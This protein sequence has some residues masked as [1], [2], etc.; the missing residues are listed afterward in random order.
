MRKIGFYLL[1]LLAMVMV[2]SCGNDKKSDKEENAA[3]EKVETEK[4]EEEVDADADPA[5]DLSKTVNVVRVTGTLA[6][7]P[8]N[9]AKFSEHLPLVSSACAVGQVLFWLQKAHLQP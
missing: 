2:I 9:R 6:L 1:I 8:Q 4:G 3:S 7:D 5:P